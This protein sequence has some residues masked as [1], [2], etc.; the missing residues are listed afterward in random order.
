L[1]ADSRHCVVF[2]STNRWCEAGFWKVLGVAK[3][4]PEQ[5][6]EDALRADL[7]QAD[8]SKKDHA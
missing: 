7:H 2:L 5:A 8:V 6:L 1:P 3:E 4:G